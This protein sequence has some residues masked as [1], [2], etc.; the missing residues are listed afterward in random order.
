MIERIR[1]NLCWTDNMS[2]NE[3]IESSNKFVLDNMS[4]NERELAR[5]NLC[6]NLTN[7]L[8]GGSPAAVTSL[9][10]LLEIDLKC[11]A[12]KTKNQELT[13]RFWIYFLFNHKT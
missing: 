9:L 1:T 13:L 5:T 11:N 6:V 4:R 8:F 7:V 2:R 10:L 3:R 12:S